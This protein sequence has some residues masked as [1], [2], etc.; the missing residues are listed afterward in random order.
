MPSSLGLSSWEIHWCHLLNGRVWGKQTFERN[1]GFYCGQT[2]SI[3][4]VSR[5]AKWAVDSQVWGWWRVRIRESSMQVIDFQKACE[6]GNW[7]SSGGG[8]GFHPGVPA[9]L[10]R[11]CPFPPTLTHVASPGTSSVWPLAVECREN[12][13][14]CG[15]CCSASNP[16]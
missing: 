5:D 6:S 8:R 2:A 13:S 14:H 16:K 10:T 4:H 9:A 15:I 11:V 12:D 3:L 7:M 1:Q